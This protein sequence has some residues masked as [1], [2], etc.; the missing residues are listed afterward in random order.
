MDDTIVKQSSQR[1]TQPP[2]VNNSP[3]QSGQPAS[4]IMEP[5]SVSV[6]IE[7]APV[8]NI[9]AVEQPQELIKESVGEVSIPVELEHFVEHAPN[10]EKPVVSQAAQEAGVTVSQAYA[11]VSATPENNN[12]YPM[13]YEEAVLKKK[14]SKM[15]EAIKWFSALVIYQWKKLNPNTGK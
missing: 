8:A 1:I 12:L 5:S 3:A 10:T 2:V 15:G 7:H 14:A 9:K 4:R 11:P 13:T 6:S